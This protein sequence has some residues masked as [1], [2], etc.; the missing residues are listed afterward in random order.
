MIVCSTYL[1]HRL[2]NRRY[3]CIKL[4]VIVT[5]ICQIIRKTKLKKKLPSLKGHSPNEFEQSLHCRKRFWTQDCPSCLT[6]PINQTT[7]VIS[8]SDIPKHIIQ[9]LMSS[10][11]A[12]SHCYELVKH[13]NLKHGCSAKKGGASTKEKKEGT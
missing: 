12:K 2:I 1:Q 5:L 8:R 13:K 6:H 4:S 10:P 11:F 9:D 7:G 3:G